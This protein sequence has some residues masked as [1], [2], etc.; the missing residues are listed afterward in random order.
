MKICL[1]CH[2]HLS[3]F[4]CAFKPFVHSLPFLFILCYSIMPSA[5]A[6]KA[7]ISSKRTVGDDDES[8]YTATKSAQRS[9]TTT[10]PTKGQSK[11]QR[12]ADLEGA[13]VRRRSSNTLM[14][15]RFPKPEVP[16]IPENEL[17]VQVSPSDGNIQD[18]KFQEIDTARSVNY[19]RKWGL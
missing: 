8:D 16:R 7:S 17:P 3:T 18:H 6:R 14:K 1:C 12:T 15:P 13:I 2:E 4:W 19:L 11:R 9:K 5:T 10:S